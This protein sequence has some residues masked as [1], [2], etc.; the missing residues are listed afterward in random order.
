MT[1]LFNP[2]QSLYAPNFI[3]L[4]VMQQG[5]ELNRIIS[6]AIAIGKTSILYEKDVYPM[7]ADILRYNGFKVVKSPQE[8]SLNGNPVKYTISW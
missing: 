1:N 5:Q 4:L 3:D 2:L 6:S 8:L 7:N